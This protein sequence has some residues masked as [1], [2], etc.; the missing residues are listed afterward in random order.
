[1]K[2]QVH[3]RR[4][5]FTLVEILV[6]ISI[7]ALLAALLFPVFSSARENA[8]QKTAPPTCNKFTSR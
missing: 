7:I 8:R 2:N 5:A 4:S 6:V 3:S 1:M